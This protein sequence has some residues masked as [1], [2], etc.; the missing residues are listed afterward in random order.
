MLSL[1]CYICLIGNNDSLTIRNNFLTQY[2]ITQQEN[3]RNTELRGKEGGVGGARRRGSNAVPI[4]LIHRE[5]SVA[6]TFGFEF[7]SF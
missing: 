4:I 7:K 5:E 2:V 6:Q 3:S 1:H